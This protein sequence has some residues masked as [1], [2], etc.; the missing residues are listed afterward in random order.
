MSSL[1]V[2]HLKN[3]QPKKPNQQANKKPHNEPLKPLYGESPFSPEKPGLPQ[4]WNHLFK[5]SPRATSVPFTTRFLSQI[6]SHT[7]L[8]TKHDSAVLQLHGCNYISLNSQKVY[9][10]LLH[11][12]F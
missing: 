5:Q 6:I 10:L 9:D 4:N 7:Q 1:L 3:K 11:L 8:N 12:F 2:M